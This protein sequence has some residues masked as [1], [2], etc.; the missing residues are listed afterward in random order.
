M[1][2]R[3]KRIASSRDEKA[4]VKSARVGNVGRLLRSS[5]EIS[6]GRKEGSTAAPFLYT[7]RWHVN[8]IVCRE[9]GREGGCVGATSRSAEHVKMNICKQTLA[10]LRA[11]RGSFHDGTK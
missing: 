5:F 9:E 10:N 7:V 8:F 4:N 11:T 3:S 1:E 6:S 2:E